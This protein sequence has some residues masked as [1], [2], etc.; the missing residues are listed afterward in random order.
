MAASVD[1]SPYN[2]LLW[3]LWQVIF[4]ALAMNVTIVGLNQIYDKKMDKVQT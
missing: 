2:T 3:K 1:S 4:C